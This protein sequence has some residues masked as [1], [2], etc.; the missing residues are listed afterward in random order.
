MCAHHLHVRTK[1][2]NNRKL[3]LVTL[4]SNPYIWD[5]EAK[6]SRVQDHPMLQNGFEASLNSHRPYSRKTKTKQNKQQQQR[7]LPQYTP[8]CV[9]P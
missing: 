3:G 8:T 5:A 9:S 2:K 4:A 1:G 7:V 6:E